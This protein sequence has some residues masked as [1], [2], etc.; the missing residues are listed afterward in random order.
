M[1][2]QYAY[3]RPGQPAQELITL[4]LSIADV[5]VEPGT[6]LLEFLF[7]SGQ[8]GRFEVAAGPAIFVQ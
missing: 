5:S 2:A 3:A 4:D 6:Y 7:P 1:P 8:P